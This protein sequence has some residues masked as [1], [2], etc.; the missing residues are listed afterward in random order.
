MSF[1]LCNCNAMGQPR[2]FLF[3][4]LL[5]FLSIIHVIITLIILIFIFFFCITIAFWN[6]G[7]TNPEAVEI[8]TRTIHRNH[9]LYKMYTDLFP[10]LSTGDDENRM[11][12]KTSVIQVNNSNI[13]CLLYLFLITYHSYS[14]LPIFLHTFLTSINQR[15][16]NVQ[17]FY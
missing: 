9:E 1:L 6:L 8:N 17:L 2:L 11:I 4:L 5:L 7:F 14:F 12:A 15:F 10:F 13:S 16:L 3:L